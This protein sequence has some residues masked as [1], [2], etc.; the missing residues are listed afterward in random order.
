MFGFFEMI[1]AFLTRQ[2]GPREDSAN[3]NGSLHSKSSK[4]MSDV[5]YE[6]GYTRSYLNGRM[7]KPRGVV[8][9]GDFQSESSWAT[10][11]TTTGRGRLSGIVLVRSSSSGT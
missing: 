11:Y 3:A 1:F 7:Q 10:A 9:V 4:I 8:D 6:G 5:S 2:L